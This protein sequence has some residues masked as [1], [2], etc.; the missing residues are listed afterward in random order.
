MHQFGDTAGQRFGRRLMMLR[1]AISV[2]TGL[3]LMSRYAYRS[4]L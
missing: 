4:R 3:I 2:I 1:M